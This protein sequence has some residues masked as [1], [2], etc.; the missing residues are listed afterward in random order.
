M[1]A[2]IQAGGKGTR[3]SS[4]THNEIPKPMVEIAGKP[5]LT[6]QMN[7]LKKNG[8]T[9][10]ILIIGYLGRIIQDYYGDGSSLGIK[11]Q[12]IH[13]DENKPLGTA[14]ALAYLSPLLKEENFIFVYA[15]AFFSLEVE[16][17]IAF[18]RSHQSQATLFVHP[19]SHPFDSDLV[20][21]DQHGRVKKFDS[22]HND[23]SGYDYDNIVNAGVFVFNRCICDFVPIPQKLALE[24]DVIEQMLAQG[25]PVYGYMSSEYVKDAGTVERLQSVEND[26]YSG[27]I[28][29]RNFCNK[30]KAIFLDRDG[31]LNKYVGLLSKK[32]QLE[33]ED[34]VIEAVKVINSSEYLAICCTNQPVVARGMCSIDELEAIHRRL[35]TLLGKN[36]AY[37]DD[38]IYCPHHPDKGYAEEN[39]SYKISCNCRKPQ[40]GMV[41]LMAQKHNI[42]LAESWFI[43]DTMRDMQTALNAG[44][45]KALVLTGEAGQDHK[46]QVKPDFQAEALLTIV[47]KIIRG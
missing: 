26:L 39:P 3:L 1:Q 40:T 44:M 24:H 5:L 4:I 46:Y 43:G 9:E 28:W 2:V 31:T 36:G 47:N 13:E 8:V 18:H 20:V 29:Q 30:Q 19:N 27:V 15:D 42:D 11:I 17:F 7:E 33:M 32:E 35:Q 34:T 6:W 41:E 21:L 25:K 12:Y 37:L 16:R 22:K 23:R 38:I 10:I 45:Q 14:G